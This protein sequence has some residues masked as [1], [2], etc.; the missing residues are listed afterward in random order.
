MANQLAQS[1]SPYLLQHKDNPVDWYPWGDEAFQKA[2][3]EDKPVFLSIGYA[4]C[5][6]C[7]VMA[8]ESFEDEAVA[9]RMND[10]FVPVKVDREERPDIDQLYMSVCQMMRGNGGWPLNVLLTPDK[11]PFYAATYLPKQGRM[12]R[13]GMMDLMERIEALW[14]QERPKLEQE[15]EKIVDLLEQEGDTDTVDDTPTPG[16]LESSVQQFSRQFDRT[17]GGFG[18][19]PK[20]PMP[21][22]PLFLTTYGAAT[23]TDYAVEMATTTLRHIVR[24]GINDHVGGGIHRYATDAIWRLPHFEKMLYDQGLLLM[25]LSDAHRIAP[26][27]GWDVH[28]DDI[29]TYL[30]RDLLD[31]T[32][33]FY[34]AED[35]DS[36]DPETGESREGAFYTWTVDAIREHLDADTAARFVTVYSMQEQGNFKEEATGERTGENVLDRADDWPAL[37]DTLDTTPEALRTEM[38]AA[39]QTL[40]NVREGRPRP[41]LDDK[42]LTDW[43]G[44]LLAGL[45]RAG[46]FVDASYLA[47]A[48]RVA[49]FLCDTMRTDDGRLLH[50]Y[51]NGS[52][53]IDATL[54]DYA[55]LAW[56][57]LDLYDATLN[58][59]WLGEARRIA[60][61]L[62]RDFADEE[63][64][65]FY[66][67]PE[68]A[69]D[70]IV[71]QQAISGGA[72]PS[73]TGVA[74]YVLHRLYRM[75]GTTAFAET[76]EQ[77]LQ[78]AGRRMR[79]QPTQHVTLL[80]ALH[81]WH[82]AGRE[83]VLAGDPSD[84]A[85]RK[86]LETVRAHQAPEDVV[87]HRP[88]ADDHE[89]FDWAPYLAHQPP[90]DGTATAYV[91]EGFTCDAPTTS[92]ETLAKQLTQ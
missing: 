62:C 82:H 14:T 27:A 65:G 10:L 25:A 60:H 2:K 67:A 19:A 56:G 23:G 4:T 74:V 12:G 15:A 90:K 66:M 85:Y 71:R 11:R 55:Y 8:H 63:R 70:V 40:F 92:P 22:T 59:R 29:V 33:A 45:S 35:A 50:R 20:F 57:L 87:V 77:A 84:D 26:D 30:T 54:T 37:A 76:A 68:T 16:L 5:H 53:G 48:K 46:Q 78:R 24:G 28:I 38:E 88:P 21:H 41:F 3:A 61:T 79:S 36:E 34:S 69:E 51:R 91:C 89:L 73:G 58:T 80:W 52:A 81:H 1:E 6:W 31:E 9:A 17:H 72:R 13:M 42:I 64:G 7:H 43:N 39:C 47:P 83:I 32:G 75:L 44:L 86:L 49:A 18:G